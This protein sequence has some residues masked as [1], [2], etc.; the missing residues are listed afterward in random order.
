MILAPA[1]LNHPSY[2]PALWQGTM[3]FWGVMTVAILFNAYASKILPKLESFILFIHILGFFAIL[4]PLVSV[5]AGDRS[6][7]QFRL[8]ITTRCPPERSQLTMFSRCFRME[9]VGRPQQCQS[10]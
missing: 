10:L 5:G 7:V 2:N 1:Q 3:V 4:I 8:L 6:Q 9:V